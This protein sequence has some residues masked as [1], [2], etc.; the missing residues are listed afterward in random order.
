M[1][2]TRQKPFFFQFQN[3][4]GEGRVKMHFNFF[5]HTNLKML[6]GKEGV[7]ITLNQRSIITRTQRRIR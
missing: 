5:S 1:V 3:T 4:A 6:L 7:I 2:K